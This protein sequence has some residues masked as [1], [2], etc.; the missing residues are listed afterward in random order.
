MPGALM[1][2]LRARALAI[3]AL[4]AALPGIPAAAQDA[5]RWIPRA[6]MPIVRNEAAGAAIGDRIYMVGG[7][8]GSGSAGAAAELQIYSPAGDTWD[9]G[10][11]MPVGLHHP[12]VAA[13]GG[14]LYVLGGCDHGTARPGTSPWRGSRHAFEYDPGADSWRALKPLPRSSAAGALLP[15]GGRLYLIGG[16]DTDGV[17]LDLVQ[18]YD[19]ATETWRERA[20]MPKAREHIGAAALD[21]LLYVAGGRETGTGGVSIT[22]FQAY[23]PVRDQWRTLPPLPTARSGLSLAAAKGKLYALGGEWPGIFDLNEEYDPAR[24]S[25]RTVAKMA[26]R[27]HGFA[28]IPYRDTVYAMGF[29]QATEAFIAPGPSLSTRPRSGAGRIR[30][31]RIPGGGYRAWGIL[32]PGDVDA[33]GRRDSRPVSGITGFRRPN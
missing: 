14:K 25:W 33:A 6:G 17:V 21:S 4:A 30:E 31:G 11:K 22:A 9:F 12:N 27:R 10:A 2:K 24:G 28:A 13:A 26:N 3:L 15:W 1:L 23:D 16:V 7:F 20:R 5:G 29:V 19:P 18:E 32:L 8:A